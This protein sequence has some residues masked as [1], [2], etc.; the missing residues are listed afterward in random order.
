MVAVI[1]DERRG[2]RD[3]AARLADRV[4]AAEH[5][6]VDLSRVEVVAL[7]DGA[8]CRLGEPERRHLMQGAVRLAAAAR[9]ADVIVDERVGHQALLCCD[10]I[11]GRSA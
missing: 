4:D 6:V 5:H 1:G 3:V 2:P 10:V 11:L 9:G 8:Q 7:T